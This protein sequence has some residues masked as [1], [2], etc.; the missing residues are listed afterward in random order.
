M[1]TVRYDY[2][3]QT[4]FQVSAGCVSKDTI[5]ITGVWQPALMLTLFSVKGIV[6]LILILSTNIHCEIR[7]VEFVV[8]AAAVPRADRMA[9]PSSFSNIV[10]VLLADRS[11]QAVWVVWVAWVVVAGVARGM[12]GHC[13][14]SKRRQRM[15]KPVHICT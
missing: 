8:C 15:A 1:G 9:P 12:H 10:G 4:G 7:P 13:I 11:G 6:R 3:L 5:G 14:S 2:K